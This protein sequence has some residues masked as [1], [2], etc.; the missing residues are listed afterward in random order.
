MEYGGSASDRDNPHLDLAWLKKHGCLQ[1]TTA[2]D[3][4]DGD[5]TLGDL[6]MYRMPTD[7]ELKAARLSSIF[8]GYYLRWDP[9]EN[10]EI[11]ARLGFEKLEDGP[12][13]GLYDFADL[14]SANIV[15]HHYIKWIKF[16]MTRLHD[17]VAIEIRSGRMTREEGV[18][19]LKTRAERYPAEEIARLCAFIGMSE[20]EFWA[21]LDRFRNPAVWSR[22]ERGEWTISGHLE[23]LE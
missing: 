5:L 18:R 8:L 20:A 17:H 1:G 23:G 13:L 6:N 15:V 10:Y 3:W 9:I 7:Q 12:R 11:A 16:G 14:D 2:E 22:D 19:I 4:A 21:A